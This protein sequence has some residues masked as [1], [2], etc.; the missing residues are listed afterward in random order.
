MK[1]IRKSYGIQAATK[2]KVTTMFTSEKNTVKT[3]YERW[4]WSLYNKNKE[5]N[6]LRISG[7]HNTCAPNIRMCKYSNQILMDVKEEI[8]CTITIGGS[9]NIPSWEMGRPLR[10]RIKETMKLNNTKNQWAWQTDMLTLGP[11]VSQYTFFPAH[12]QN[13]QGRTHVRAQNKSLQ[14][15]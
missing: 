10:L 4:R 14:V 2:T 11:I 1:R 12:T 6:C 13:S 15:L 7:N 9:F 5:V 3:S 8:N